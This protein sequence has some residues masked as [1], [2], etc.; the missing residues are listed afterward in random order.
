[1]GI[2][3]EESERL[4]FVLNSKL[5]LRFSNKNDNDN[6]EGIEVCCCS[7]DSVITGSENQIRLHQSLF[8]VI[9]QSI[10]A[11]LISQ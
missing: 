9:D 5:I 8:K 2:H 6:D 10:S 3:N 11:A 1:M 4:E 7:E